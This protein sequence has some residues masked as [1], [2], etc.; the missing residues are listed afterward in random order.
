[1]RIAIASG[2]FAPCHVG[3]I[4]YLKAAAALGDMLYVIVNNDLQVGLKGG[5]KFMDE[6]ERLA[7][8]R[9]LRP[10]DYA[11]LSIDMNRSVCDTISWIVASHP[12]GT[13]F[14]F[15]N[16]GDVGCE[17]DCREAETC[18]KL[19]VALAFGV[20]GTAKLQ[21]SSAILANLKGA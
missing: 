4:A 10:V 6:N 21:S 17:A 7:I 3:H 13:A 11:C 2:H 12:A 19:G 20:G 18:K 5:K 9:S 15:C 8:V 14:V 1:M 16:G